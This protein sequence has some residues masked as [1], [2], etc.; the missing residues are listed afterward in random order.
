MLYSCSTRLL[1]AIHVLR[2]CVFILF[3]RV[4]L[5][6][7]LYSDVVVLAWCEER[8]FLVTRY[9]S[10]WPISSQLLLMLLYSNN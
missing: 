1:P 10:S 7:V 5:L 4:C 8:H 2:A 6:L 3:F 9:L